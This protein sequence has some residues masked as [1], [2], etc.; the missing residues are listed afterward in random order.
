MEPPSR[1]SF[2]YQGD[3]AE[4]VESCEG[5]TGASSGD[6]AAMRLGASDPSTAIVAVAAAQLPLGR[7]Y[8]IAT[9]SN[10]GSSSEAGLPTS[11]A[12]NAR[13]GLRSAA[14]MSVEKPV[15]PA[16]AT[17]DAPSNSNVADVPDGMLASG[18]SRIA[19][20]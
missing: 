2:L 6:G 15:P 9:V 8:G 4:D 19:G 1:T 5:C 3:A 14:S 13:L 11:V 18:G 17:P 16:P 7:R 12:R 20:K 10:V